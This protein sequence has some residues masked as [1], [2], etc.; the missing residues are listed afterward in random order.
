MPKE[1]AK[2]TKSA[3]KNILWLGLFILLFFVLAIALW[4]LDGGASESGTTHR[5]SQQPCLQRSNA[6]NSSCIARLERADS[7]QQHL[8]GLSDRTKLDDG[9]GMLFTF[10]YSANQCMWMK[11]MRFAIDMVWLDQQKEVIKV[12]SNVTPETYPTTF[13]ADA[14]KYVIELKS[15]EVIKNGIEPGSKLKF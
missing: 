7:N 1:N 10:K 4:L 8:R 3:L 11:D 12:E 14:T 13:C 9:T 6:T 5:Q 2:K 15:G